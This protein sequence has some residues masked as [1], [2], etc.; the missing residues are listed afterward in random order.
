MIASFAGPIWKQR[1]PGVE[2]TPVLSPS[3]TA[4]RP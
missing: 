3:K 1:Y 2:S 4:K